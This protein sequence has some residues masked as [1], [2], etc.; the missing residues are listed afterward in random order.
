MAQGD[1][2]VDDVF[3]DEDIFILDIVVEVLADFEDT[4]RRRRRTVA[5]AAHEIEVDR[6]IDAAG[7]VGEK[8]DGP[9]E[10][11]AHEDGLA[12]IIFG[13]LG[14][15]FVNAGSNLFFCQ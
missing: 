1:A 10:D 3:D 12:G 4:G 14:A 2:R 13:D 7:Q 5:G 11:A 15:Q 8:G 9:F 6:A